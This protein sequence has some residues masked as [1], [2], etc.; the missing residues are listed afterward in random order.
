MTSHYSAHP[1]EP[2]DDD[3]ALRCLWL[4]YQVT[5][6][7]GRDLLSRAR[8]PGTGMA[9]LARLE[10]Q[11]TVRVTHMTALDGKFIVEAG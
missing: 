1:S 7:T 10:N 8:E 3:E 6:M 5:G 9:A 2:V 11:R 4:K